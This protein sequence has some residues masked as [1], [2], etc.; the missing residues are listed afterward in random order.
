[1]PNNEVNRKTPA[2]ATP[3]K[4]FSIVEVIVAMVI[5]SIIVGTIYGLLQV[6]LIDRNRASRRS[7]MLKNARA[8][9]HLVGRDALNAGLSYNKNGAVVPDNFVSAR[10]G[11]PN[12]PDDERDRL[13]SIVGG[14]NLFTNTLNPAA[15]TDV[16]AFA[17][18]DTNFNDGN[19]V[20]VNNATTGANS[21][22]VRLQTPAGGAANARVFDLYLVETDSSQ[23]AVMATG[24][25]SANTID[26]APADPLSINQALNGTGS[27]VS[28]LRPCNPPSLTENCTVYLNAALK[29]VFWVVYKVKTDGTLVRQIFGN[30]TGASAAEQIQEM[31]IAYN[32]ED[33][34]VRY[35]LEDG[36][37]TDHPGAGPDLAAGTADDTPLNFNLVRQITVS[38]KVQA[39][40]NDEQ[41]GRPQT[42]TLS[43]SFSTRN[44]EYDAG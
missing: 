6:G 40:E 37:T 8:A 2:A 7:D 22:T 3:E 44:L 28:I 21:A 27:G 20:S 30:N 43:A 17:Y 15:R 38:L 36:T 41:Q 39:T 16:L 11:L 4:G 9:V 10:L 5:F 29:R 14:D 13:T 32:V 34:Q 26:F 18:R 19:A 24:V 35:V 25:P 31:P 33:F 42:I 1:M 12:D 23:V